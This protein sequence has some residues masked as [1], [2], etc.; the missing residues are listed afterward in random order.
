MMKN[1]KVILSL[2]TRPHWCGESKTILPKEKYLQ[3]KFII[4]YLSGKQDNA[5][6][7]LLR[8]LALKAAPDE[9]NMVQE[10]DLGAAVC[11]DIGSI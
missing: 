10:S 4:E 3:F 1:E 5:D 11:S 2:E 9:D 6:D 7:S 8:F